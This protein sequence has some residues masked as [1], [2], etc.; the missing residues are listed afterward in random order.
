LEAPSLIHRTSGVALSSSN[1]VMFAPGQP[2]ASS[3]PSKS[4]GDVRAADVELA[5]RCQDGDATAFEEVYRAHAGRLYSLLFR[6]AGSAQDAE[7][8][9]QDV[10][11]HAYRKLG[12]FRGDS[13][14]GTWL[15]RLAVNHCLDVLRG[16]RTKMQKA[17]DSL[18]EEDAK[19]PA[20]A[21][22]VIPTAIS[23]LDLDRAIAKLPE[24]C[25]AAFVLHDVEGFEHHEVASLLGV[26]QG[27]SKSQVHK[28]RMKL[29]A[30][31]SG[32][33]R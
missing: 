2:L 24:G 32:A 3:I 19:E 27:T 16:R 15:Y 13:T 1:P 31:L 5:R 12:S 22:P 17:T 25:R 26:S 21:M 14:L 20:A 28:A 10:F 18:D 30:L 8:L 11:L 23:R 33:T 6:M 29:R 9:L 7:D 4:A